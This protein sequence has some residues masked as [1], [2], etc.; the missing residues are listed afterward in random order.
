[1]AERDVGFATLDPGNGERFQSLRRELGVT[2]FG[3]N[4]ITLQ[5]RER[6][7]VHRHEQQEEVYVVLQGELTLILEDGEEHVLGRGKLVRVGAAE[8]RQ[9]VNRG[10]E[11][12]VMLALGGHGEHVGRDG[13]AWESWDEGG[14]GRPPQEVP[15]PDDLPG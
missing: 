3:M 11:R 4:L 8:R 12:L 1:M 5:P 6:G 2:S 15:L 10:E 9:L 13:R 14:D 7:R